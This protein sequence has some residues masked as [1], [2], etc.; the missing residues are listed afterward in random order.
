MAHRS[1]PFRPGQ[2]ALQSWGW[3]P[4]YADIS[5]GHVRG[6]TCQERQGRPDV[7]WFGVEQGG[8]RGLDGSVTSANGQHIYLLG[9]HFHQGGSDVFGSHNLSVDDLLVLGQE[10]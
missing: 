6:S 4:C 9:S 10:L 8:Q 2:Q 3:F 5:G 1:A 7:K